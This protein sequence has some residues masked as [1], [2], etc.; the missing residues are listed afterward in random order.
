MDDIDP[1]GIF[2]FFPSANLE[3][4]YDIN[5]D[6]I[7]IIKMINLGS[8]VK[9]AEIYEPFINVFTKDKGELTKDRICFTQEAINDTLL[10]IHLKISLHISISKK[11]RTVTIRKLL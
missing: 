11:S 3:F 6:I 1:L 7:S 5:S 8:F 4:V 9:H 2:D 10:L